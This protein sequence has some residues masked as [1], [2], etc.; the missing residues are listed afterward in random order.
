MQKIVIATVLCLS[1]LTACNNN[2]SP[3]NSPASVNMNTTVIQ[4]SGGSTAR[5]TDYFTF[6]KDVHMEYK[7]TGNEYAG[8]DTYVDYIKN[9]VI[10]VRQINGATE[11]VAVYRL[12]D[13]ILKKVFTKGEVYYR[14]DYTSLSNCDEVIIKEPIKAGAS[15]TLGD[16]SERSITAV[17]KQIK[18]PAGELTALEITT[19][20]KNF[21]ETRYYAKN[22]GLVKSEFLSGDDSSAITSEL[23]KIERGVPFK[24]KIRFYF[25]QFEKD[26]VVYIDRDTEIYTNQDMKYIFQKELKTLPENSG[27]TKVLSPNTAIL[28]IS[29]DEAAGTVTV[30][31]SSN[32]VKEMNAGTALESMVLQSITDIF[33]NYYQK[34]K[35]IITMEGKLYESGHIALKKGEYFTVD[36][37]N[38]KQYK[39]P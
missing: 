24:Q 12:K 16:G 33:G 6:T 28:G 25:P 32:L 20:S 7:G 14:Y 37:D 8:Y 2:V 5:I 36:K 39:N 9:D 18:T 31:F 21:T 30:D 35:V 10:Q 27:L 17:D 19:K 22:I 4:P 3:G 34:D 15:W 13:G 38:V 26:R 29:V 1:M 23:E 11:S